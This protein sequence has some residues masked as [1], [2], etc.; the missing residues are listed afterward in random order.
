MKSNKRSRNSVRV[1]VGLFGLG[2]LALFLTELTIHGNS[3]RN[4]HS[5]TALAIS[6]PIVL[7]TG[8]PD[9]DYIRLG[10]AIAH[11]AADW[12]IN[13][14]VCSSQGSKQNLQ[15]LRKED[16]GITFALVQSDALHDEVFHAAP[17]GSDARPLSLVTYL[18]NEKVHLVLRPHFYLGSLGDLRSMEDRVWLGPK[19]SGSRATT[20]RILEAAGLTEKEIARLGE[21][22]EKDWATASRDLVKGDLQVFFR[23][24]STPPKQ[25]LSRPV[26]VP[27]TIRPC[28]REGDAPGHTEKKG[29]PVP[30][31]EVDPIEALLSEDA[32]LVG[33]APE[34]ID[35]MTEDGL[36]ERSAIPL[37]T[38]PKLR[39]GVP[40]ISLSTALV[41]SEGRN[42]PAAAAMISD[43][44]D[45]LVENQS[46][47][48]H[49]LGGIPLELLRT[50]LD[51][52]AA[53]KWGNYVHRGAR[54]HLLPE[55]SW[56]MAGI[57][58]SAL[59]GV[60]LLLVPRVRRWVRNALAKSM[61]PLLL[62]AIMASLWFAFSWGMV[63]AEG[64]F[65]PDFESVFTSMRKMLGYVS[66]WSGGKET[67]TPQGR[68]LLYL[69]VFAVP[70]VFGWLTSDVIHRG[71]EKAA[72]WLSEAVFQKAERISPSNPTGN[73][74]KRKR[75]GFRR[76][77]RKVIGKSRGKG[78][79]PPF[80]APNPDWAD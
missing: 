1:A 34:I 53:Q 48:E 52:E 66:G 69:A 4:L 42:D 38:Y 68:T 73:P 15:F 74:E 45:I 63:L 7:A 46:A 28:N 78:P 49:E 44:L 3:R 9:G 54:D 62:I 25:M 37:A 22:T 26:K 58:G 13:I 36:Y 43:L 12:G 19:G 21:R 30:E 18:Y 65:N 20:E 72:S 11:I 56:Q 39:R 23:T 50:P 79:H 10:H 51:K 55:K 16:S 41:T 61:Y 29:E 32:R 47:I 14:Q 35:R 75:A 70:L 2:F 76:W 67:I 17:E 5:D 40:T 80:P 33:L 6:K 59:G 71:V 24:R 64:Q 60:L 31:T 57:E 8:L 27:N 77:A